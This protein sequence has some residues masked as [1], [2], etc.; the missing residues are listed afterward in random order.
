MR[1]ITYLRMG[2]TDVGV[3]EIREGG[4]A[5]VGGEAGSVIGATVGAA[6][7]G[8]AK[9]VSGTGDCVGDTGVASGEEAFFAA[10]R[11]AAAM[12]WAMADGSAP[13]VVSSVV[14]SSSCEVTSVAAGVS[15]D[16]VC[17]EPDVSASD[18][19]V[20]DRRRSCGG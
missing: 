16:E 2:C 7:A 12:A 20:S 8:E 14:R 4:N 11:V 19:A 17:G 1:L 18:A 5:G 15:D 3:S 6:G 10:E 9:G 13:V